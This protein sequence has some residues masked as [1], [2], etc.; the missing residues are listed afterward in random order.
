MFTIIS[1]EKII[2][3]LTPGPGPGMQPETA[4]DD[5]IVKGCLSTSEDMQMSIKLGSH[6][7]GHNGGHPRGGLG[8]LGARHERK[9]TSYSFEASSFPNRHN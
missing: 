9:R 8:T 7:L 6:K 5:Y 1:E 4:Q 3:E 2:Y